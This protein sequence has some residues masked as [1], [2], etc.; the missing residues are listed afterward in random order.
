MRSPNSP[1]VD[2]IVKVREYGAV[3]SI[4]YYVMLKSACIGLSLLTKRK[5]HW[6]ADVL[7]ESEA[8]VLPDVGVS[9][10]LAYL[11]DGMECADG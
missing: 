11:C 5:P 10:P 3:A 2:R 9:I 6:Q 4:R 7:A 1:P 8:L